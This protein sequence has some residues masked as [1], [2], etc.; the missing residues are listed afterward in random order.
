MIKLT[1]T[2]YLAADCSIKD[3]ESGNN[4]AIRFAVGVT[5]K[6]K[7]AG[8]NQQSKTSWISCTYWRLA[9]ETGIAQYLKKGRQVLIEGEP[10]VRAWLKQGSSDPSAALDCRVTYLELLGERKDP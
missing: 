10:S 8:G 2:G 1:A 3:M 9:N 4:V 7:D 6:W 5:T